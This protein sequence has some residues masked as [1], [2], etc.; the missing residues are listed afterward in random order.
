MGRR[1]IWEMNERS[2]SDCAESFGAGEYPEAVLALLRERIARY[3]MGD[4]TSVPLDTAMRLLEGIAYCVALHRASA[5]SDVPA[6]APLRERFFAG[7]AE[8]KRRARR[9]KLLLGEAQRWQ[10]PLVNLGFRDTLAALPSFFRSYDADFFAGEIPCSIDYPLCQPCSNT[11]LGV[12]YVQDYLRRWLVESAFLRGFPEDALLRLYERYYGDF[13]GLLVNLYLPVAEM[14]V[15]CALGNAPVRS[16]QLDRQAKSEIA[17]VLGQS[18]DTAA[19][20]TVRA[21]AACVSDALPRS[22]SFARAYL[23]QTALDLQIRLCAI[24]RKEREEL[25]G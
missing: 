18:D 22:D 12:A 5:N 24:A 7:V 14:A 4:S 1:R 9:A 20:K 10:P 2:L 3:T 17:G 16:L 19:K 11:L 25:R 6:D 21:A 13:D 8:A 15:L 23:E